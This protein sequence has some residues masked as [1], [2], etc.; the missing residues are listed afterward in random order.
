MDGS[1]KPEKGIFYEIAKRAENDQENNYLLGIDEI[2]RRNIS[3]IFGALMMLIEN[4]KRDYASLKLAYSKDAF[5][6]PGNL[7]I[8]GTMN[9]A[10]RSL[11]LIDYA[12]RRRFSFLTLEPAYGTVKFNE[13]LSKAMELTKENISQINDA[14]I[15]VN[16]I[17]EERLDKNFLRSEEHTSE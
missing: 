3:T 4:D 2:N 14:M 17:I 10:D 12:L 5:S 11:S 9:T 8:I 16:S 6:V 13:F 1:F 15:H 7:Y